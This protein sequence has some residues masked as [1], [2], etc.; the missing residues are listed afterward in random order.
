MG[1]TTS[2]AN[3]QQA[4]DRIASGTKEEDWREA[5]VVLSSGSGAEVDHELLAMF[6]TALDRGEDSRAELV[7]RILAERDPDRDPSYAE[8]LLPEP[9]A[10]PGRGER[11]AEWLVGE[12]PPGAEEWGFTRLRRLEPVKHYAGQLRDGAPTARLLA[13]GN[14]G[15]TADADAFDVLLPALSDRSRNVRFAAVQSV[16][17]LAEAG[18]AEEYSG[19]AVRQRLA[20]LLSNDDRLVRVAAARTLFLFGDEELVA[21]ALSRTTWSQRKLKRELEAVLRGDVPPLPKMWI[22]ER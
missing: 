2:D 12:I 5:A 4:L 8:R 11:L 13:A 16:R 22:G 19:H 14:L 15:D 6:H 21:E 20:E 9:V 17:R 3:E 10:E 1:S 7:S 18:F